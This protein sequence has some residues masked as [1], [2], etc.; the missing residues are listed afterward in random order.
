MKFYLK[1]IYLDGDKNLIILINKKNDISRPTQEQRAQKKL[2]S[3]WKN[4]S[5]RGSAQNKTRNGYVKKLIRGCLCVKFPHGLSRLG[6]STSIQVVEQK[7]SRRSRAS[8]RVFARSSNI[9]AHSSRSRSSEMIHYPPRCGE[10]DEPGSARR[11]R[12]SA[13]R[14]SAARADLS[15]GGSTSPATN[16]HSAG[17][18]LQDRRGSILLVSNYLIRVSINPINVSK[19]PSNP[20][21][22]FVP[23][24]VV[25]FYS[26]IKPRKKPKFQAVMPSFLRA[27]HIAQCQDRASGEFSVP[28]HLVC[29]LVCLPGSHD[30]NMM[31]KIEAK[32]QHAKKIKREIE[33]KREKS[34][35]NVDC[36]FH[37]PMRFLL[38][39]TN[40]SIMLAWIYDLC[41]RSFIAIEKARK[42]R[43]MCIDKD[44]FAVSLLLGLLLHI[45]T[46]CVHVYKCEYHHWPGSCVR[47][48]RKP[49]RPPPIHACQ[50]V[51]Q[52]LSLLLGERGGNKEQ[53]ELLL[54]EVVIARRRAAELRREE[55]RK[56]LLVSRS[57]LF[58]RGGWLY[59]FLAN[60][61]SYFFLCCWLLLPPL[62]EHVCHRATVLPPAAAPPSAHFSSFCFFW[63]L[64]GDISRNCSSAGCAR[65]LARAPI[66][67][68]SRA[69]WP[70]T[71]H[72]CAR[73]RLYYISIANKDEI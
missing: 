52:K 24:R 66:L 39:F 73:G 44:K 63:P 8:R 30:E 65:Q 53:R 21:A 17:S 25:F 57:G 14:P 28:F 7:M 64:A 49:M 3:Q 43:E 10:S 6:K 19:N 61:H 27:G 46:Q 9:V 45:N 31:R 48:G 1:L 69:F 4:E 62:H 33:R 15:F 56:N 42:G 72:V 2:Q 5:P 67:H 16:A 11:S 35:M 20:R 37:C 18:I 29:V 22:Q 55:A 60:A 51:L 12:T 50:Q 34:Q 40:P 26:S 70:A 32:A 23:I 54:R 47:K 38:L 71:E 13:S 59:T 68:E 58:I 41:M 36:F